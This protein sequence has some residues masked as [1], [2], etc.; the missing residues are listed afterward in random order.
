[1][2]LVLFI[3]LWNFSPSIGYIERSYLIDVRGFTPA[4]FA[5]F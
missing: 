4:A 5:L 2:L 1:M 3:V